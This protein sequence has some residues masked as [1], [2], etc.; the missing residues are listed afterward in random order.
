V[1]PPL[2]NWA[3]NV[4]FQAS[5]VHRPTSVGELQEVVAGS[6]RAR[7]LGTGHSFSTVADTTGDLI[8][9]AELPRSVSVDA[10]RATVTT[11]A[12]ISYGELAALLH[13]Q[14]WA[15]PNLGSLPQ[16][17]VAGACAT[18]THGSGRGLG[19]LA[20]SVSGLQMVRSDGELVR[21]NRCDNDFSGAVVA[22]GCLGVVTAVTLD[23]VP[24]FDVRQIV[25]VDLP[26][27]TASER[28]DD[29]LDSAYSVSI[30]TDWRG[31][32]AQVWRKDRVGL[33]HADLGPHWLGATGVLSPTHPV[34]GMD[35]DNTTEQLGVPGPWHERLPHFRID[36]TPSSGDELQSEFLVARENGAAAFDA[37]DRIREQVA[38][39]LQICEIRTV[40]A[41]DLWL[42]MA[43]GRSSVAVHFTWV[44]DASAVAPALRAVEQAL[45]PFDPRPHW[46]KLF[47]MAPEVVR[48]R[49]ENLVDFQRLRA[50][51][52]PTNKLG[53]GFV[54][55][56]LGDPR[57][58]EA[59]SR[60]FPRIG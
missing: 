58:G 12:G 36:A 11:S 40:A 6:S 46:G 52:D 53:N 1:T 21:I 2:T 27:T 22:L 32:V 50:A 16:I 33:D 45:A 35:V 24:T 51:L 56:Y 43:Q 14:G 59:D 4:T 60:V 17:S 42:S 15:L 3:R 18:G 13:A 28:F 39:A 30:F 49:Y 54:D 19:A 25:Y 26:L 9:V 44:D 34:P 20:T 48:E 57:N 47:T 41:D 7:A 5:H 10:E 38:P 29:V 55:R 23:V 37:V 8:S 31:D